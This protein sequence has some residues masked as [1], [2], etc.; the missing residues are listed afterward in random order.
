[1]S[2]VVNQRAQARPYLASKGIKY[3]EIDVDEIPWSE[4][5]VKKLAGG[6]VDKV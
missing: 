2:S 3:E 5:E 6:N 1:M 4:G